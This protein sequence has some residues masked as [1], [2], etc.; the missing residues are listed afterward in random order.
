MEVSVINTAKEH[1]DLEQSLLCHLLENHALFYDAE[2]HL[3][4]PEEAEGKLHYWYMRQLNVGTKR[5]QKLLRSLREKGLVERSDLKRGRFKNSSAMRYLLTDR[6]RLLAY[7]LIKEKKDVLP[8]E[9]RYMKVLVKAEEEQIKEE[10]LFAIKGGAIVSIDIVAIQKETITAP[11]KKEHILVKDDVVIV[12]KQVYE[13]RCRITVKGLQFQI[14]PEMY[15]K[16]KRVCMVTEKEIHDFEY[17][18]QTPVLEVCFSSITAL[19]QGTHAR[20]ILKEWRTRSSF[21]RS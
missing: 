3:M 19:K 7:E 12:T 1:T 21:D 17:C 18:I 14:D 16:A 13:G 20:K 6:G 9:E 2:W 8:P 10:P 11:V 5:L 15:E 4:I